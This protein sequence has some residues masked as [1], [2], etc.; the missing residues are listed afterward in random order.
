M[1]LTS[2][3]NRYP[4]VG[5][6]AGRPLS[7]AGG[8]QATPPPPPPEQDPELGENVARWLGR[9]AQ[10]VANLPQLLEKTP[11]LKESNYL[12]DAAP[13]IRGTA[14][15]AGAVSAFALSTA[16]ALEID[17]GVRH[18]N[19]AEILKGTSE[20]ARAGYVGG[21]TSGQLLKG[22]FWQNS[23]LTSAGALSFVSGALQTAGGIA[24]MRHQARE[25]NPVSPKVVGL[26]E[27][28]IGMTWVGATLGLP[29]TLC[30]VARMGLSATKA[31]YTNQ[32]TWQDWTKTDARGKV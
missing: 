2:S 6:P 4:P 25:D 3:P 18:H 10:G 15:L 19:T 8:P 23:L 11:W 32:Q 16:G 26:L 12:R 22:S 17:D 5:I 27:A 7:P 30:L 13:V 21:W 28:G 29:V 24:R 9:G 1:R 31:L 14:G 20:I